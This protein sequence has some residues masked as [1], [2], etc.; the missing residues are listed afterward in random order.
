MKMVVS[1][2]G[3]ILTKTLEDIEI[4]LEEEDLG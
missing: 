3:K 4:A 2:Q 1:S